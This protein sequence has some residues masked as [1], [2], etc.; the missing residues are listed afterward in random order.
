MKNLKINKILLVIII[1]NLIFINLTPFIVFAADSN[2]SIRDR[3]E[4]VGIAA[5]WETG[6]EETG[7]AEM[8]ALVIRLFLSVVG[9]I[10]LILI[11]YSGFRWMTSG[12]NEE[13]VK[14]AKETMVAAVIGLVI[15]LAA[16]AI[17]YFV[18]ENLADI[19]GGGGGGISGS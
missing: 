17:T 12:G 13:T 6:N 18:I 11:F 2:A 10:F 5:G 4:N 7:V 9:I 8:V 16:Y 19:G 1:L 3:L 14:K 15:V